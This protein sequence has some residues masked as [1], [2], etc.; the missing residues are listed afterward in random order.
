VAAVVVVV[1]VLAAVVLVEPVEAC[2][3]VEEEAGEE[4]EQA[5]SIPPSASTHSNAPVEVARRLGAG[6]SLPRHGRGR[7]GRSGMV[8]TVYPR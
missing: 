3:S 6:W 7:R 8:A 4:L 5:A 2:R 1:V